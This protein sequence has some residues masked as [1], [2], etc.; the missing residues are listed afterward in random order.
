MSQWDDMDIWHDATVVVCLRPSDFKDLPNHPKIPLR[1]LVDYVGPHYL[2]APGG[3]VIEKET[4]AF[5]IMSQSW[6]LTGEELPL[7]LWKWTGRVGASVYGY[8]IFEGDWA[9]VDLPWE[10]EEAV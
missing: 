1:G 8:L 3:V 9:P 5:S 10:L 2:T 6:V 4:I 7:R